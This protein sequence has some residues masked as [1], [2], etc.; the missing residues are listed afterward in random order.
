MGADMHEVE[1]EKHF[2]PH[3]KSCWQTGTCHKVLLADE[4]LNP[5]SADGNTWSKEGRAGSSGALRTEELGMHL[6]PKPPSGI[7]SNLEMHK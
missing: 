2:G 5:G 3:C 4:P 7:P 6:P 1:L